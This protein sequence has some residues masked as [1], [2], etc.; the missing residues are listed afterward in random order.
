MLRLLE[1]EGGKAL[2]GVLE[3]N[4]GKLQAKKYGKETTMKVFFFFFSL[5]SSFSPFLSFSPLKN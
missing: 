5:S 1:G 2:S 4:N 3:D